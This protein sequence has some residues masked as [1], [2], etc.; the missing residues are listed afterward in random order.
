MWLKWQVEKRLQNVWCGSTSTQRLCLLCI[1]TNITTLGL[2]TKRECDF[3]ESLVGVKSSTD[4]IR[5]S[6]RLSWSNL[7]GC[8]ASNE[9]DIRSLS[10]L[11]I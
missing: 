9:G 1:W 2:L 6:V 5:A 11:E 3:L 8:G 10:G 7:I 4:Q